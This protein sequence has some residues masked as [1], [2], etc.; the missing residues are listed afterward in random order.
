[1]QGYILYMFI[2]QRRFLTDIEPLGL[3]QLFKKIQGK[4]WEN[5]ILFNWRNRL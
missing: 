2:L 3:V 1:M 5:Y 4:L